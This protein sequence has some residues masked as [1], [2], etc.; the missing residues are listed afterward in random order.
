M[1]RSLLCSLAIA[2]CGLATAQSYAIYE[3]RSAPSLDSHGRKL[4]LATV[5]VV[6]P[7][8]KVLIYEERIKLQLSDAVAI[9]DAL[10]AFSEATGT[11]ITVFNVR[12]GAMRSTPDLPPGFPVMLDTGDPV[13]DAADHAAAKQAWMVANPELHRQ[14]IESLRLRTP[15]HE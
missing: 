2:V 13:Q 9:E 1:K 5:P 3:L 7:Q 4:L 15:S 8:A 10:A 14:Y 12:L 11:S 6:D